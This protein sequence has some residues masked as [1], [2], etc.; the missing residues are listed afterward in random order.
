MPD[1]PLTMSNFYS[2][3]ALIQKGMIYLACRNWHV[4]WSKT[5][6]KLSKGPHPIRP[7]SPVLFYDVT[8]QKCSQGVKTARWI[9]LWVLTFV[10]LLVHIAI[11]FGKWTLIYR[12]PLIIGEGRKVSWKPPPPLPSTKIKISR[13]KI[14]TCITWGMRNYM[15]LILFMVSLL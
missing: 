4:H 9:P 7:L 12:K 2:H 10:F 13:E 5:R 6:L 11:K 3:Q 15:Y 1:N 14:K 8:M